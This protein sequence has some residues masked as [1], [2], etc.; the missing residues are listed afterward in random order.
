MGGPD[1]PQRTPRP[2][3][4]VVV[5]AYNEAVRIQ[6]TLGQLREYFER[7]PYRW[8]VTLVSDGSTDGT[9]ALVRRFARTT[10]HFTLEA[11]AP[12]RG[13]GYAVRRGMLLA[14]GDLIL[15]TDADLAAPIEE[16]E[17]LLKHI[18]RVPIAIGSRPLK[19]SWLERRQPLYRELVGRLSNK[20]VQRLGVPGI[21]DTQC[22]FK[23]FRREA[24]QAIFRCVKLDGFGFDFE[25]IMIA[26]D[27]GLAVAEVPIRWAHQDGSKVVLWRDA[28]QALL[29]LLRLR[30][31]GRQG[32]LRP[33]AS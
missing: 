29:D 31:M 9:D 6:D 19:E 8:S 10:E 22:G 30:L 23:L 5:P 2:Y 13:K 26:R 33:R 32:R 7:Q 27:L 4:S 28:P 14:D 25:S 18:D 21:H 20:L 15:F 24:A 1:N 17:K 3:L 12:N 16:L 11:Y